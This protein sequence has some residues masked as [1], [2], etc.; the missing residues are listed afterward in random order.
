MSLHY[1]YTMYIPASSTLL[2]FAIIT[3]RAPIDQCVN[4]C[5]LSELRISGASVK[6]FGVDQCANGDDQNAFNWAKRS[7]VV[8]T[9]GLAKEGWGSGSGSG[10]R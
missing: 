4:L 10:M 5:D 9:P 1:I 6:C 7:T 2:I 8:F 3:D